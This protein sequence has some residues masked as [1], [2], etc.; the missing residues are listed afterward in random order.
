MLGFPSS[1][2]NQHINMTRSAS[3]KAVLRGSEGLIDAAA[4]TKALGVSRNTL[5]AYVSRGLV[6]SVAHPTVAKA[7]LYSARD[8]QGLIARKTRMR[9]PRAAAASA[10]DF[11]LPVLKS[12]ITHFEDDRLYYRAQEAVPFSRRASLEDA[13]RLLWSTGEIDPFADVAFDPRRVPGWTEIATRFARSRSTDRAIALLSLLAATETPMSGKPGQAAF[14]A[15][16]QLVVATVVAVAHVDK[17]VAGPAHEAIAAAWRRPKAAGAI[18]Q[19]LVLLADHELNASTFAVRVVASTGAGLVHC[20]LAGLAALSGPLHGAN[21]ERVRVLFTEAERSGDAY[22][23]VAKRLQRGER[24]PGFGHSLYRDGD[25]RG[26]E[27]LALGPLDQLTDQILSATRALA[28]VEPNVDFGLLALE[29][30]F[31]LPEGA[32][33]ALFAMGRSVGWIAHA[34]EQRASGT[35]IRPRAEFV[36]E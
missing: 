30:R 1:I 26:A 36:L 31:D 14:N 24:I 6:R 9:R 8:V 19:A 3:K 29:R 16:A 35:L 20:A 23:A 18:R 2:L 32:A 10:L 7:S 25:P 5:Y 33:L 4:A 11:G 28:G 21:T 27:L 22:G 13:A 12:R 17:S 34:F 15:A